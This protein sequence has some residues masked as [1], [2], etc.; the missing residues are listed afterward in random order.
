MMTSKWCYT[1]HDI[2]QK[3]KLII[4]FIR[5]RTYNIICL[6]YSQ[7]LPWA[8]N[9]INMS[10]IPDHILLQCL[11]SSISTQADPE[12]KVCE[13]GWQMNFLHFS[14]NSLCLNWSDIPASSTYT[15][16]GNGSDVSQIGNV[17]QMWDILLQKV[18]THFAACFVIEPMKF[19][20]HPWKNHN[21]LWRC[22]DKTVGKFSWIS[23]YIFQ[24]QN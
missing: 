15:V 10:S 5:D 2:I 8:Q 6:S 12:Y 14:F 18:V 13:G 7:K 1:Y 23:H 11:R 17:F 19:E 9:R 21:V 3:R 22:I 24:A 20:I 16:G 4:C